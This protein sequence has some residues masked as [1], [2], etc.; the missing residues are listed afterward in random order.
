MITT[1][2]SL[3]PLLERVLHPAAHAAA[4]SQS[5]HDQFVSRYLPYVA[6]V[7]AA[8]TAHFAFATGVPGHQPE[9]NT[10]V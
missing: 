5:T 3:A 4:A 2:T 10:N 1:T 6:E 7:Y 9:T 8:T